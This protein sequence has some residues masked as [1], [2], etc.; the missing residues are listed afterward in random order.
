MYTAIQLASHLHITIQ[1]KEDLAELDEADQNHQITRLMGFK[2]NSES[3]EVSKPV[4]L[5][6]PQKKPRY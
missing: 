1:G 5:P 2:S 4:L 6:P 3:D